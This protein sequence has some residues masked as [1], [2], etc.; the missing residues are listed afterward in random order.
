M[1]KPH[2]GFLVPLI[3]RR[4][5]ICHMAVWMKRRRRRM[6]AMKRI[7]TA[8]MRMQMTTGRMRRRTARTGWKGVRMK[9]YGSR[10]NHHT[11]ATSQKSAA[12][13]A[14]IDHQLKSS[15]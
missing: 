15:I 12:K 10:T 8:S 5:L 13:C 4:V 7:M 11:V 9:V 6:A 14:G 1:S 3:S 2:L